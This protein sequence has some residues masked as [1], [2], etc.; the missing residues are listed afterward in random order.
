MAEWFDA[1]AQ[2]KRARTEMVLNEPYEL[3][4]E[5]RLIA[6]VPE[7]GSLGIHA[8]SDIEGEDLFVQFPLAE[9]DLAGAAEEVR[10]D[11]EQCRQ[12]RPP[13]PP[14]RTLV[15][16]IREGEEL[17][18]VKGDDRWVLMAPGSVVGTLR[19]PEPEQSSTHSTKLPGPVDWA[20]T[21]LYVPLYLLLVV[22]SVVPNILLKALRFSGIMG[23]SSQSF[24][25]GSGRAVAWT[26]ETA[27]DRWDFYIP[28]HPLLVTPWWNR[29]PPVIVKQAGSGREVARFEPSDSGF[30]T[31]GILGIAEGG[32]SFF[33][34]L[35]WW[36][37]ASYRTSL[38]HYKG[39]RNFEIE[40]ISVQI[41]PAATGMPELPLL[42][43]LGLFLEYWYLYEVAQRMPLENLWRRPA[44]RPRY[45]AAPYV[46]QQGGIQ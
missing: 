4:L 40:G 14:I 3:R 25:E 31:D 38:V 30:A 17:W 43:L 32:K 5:F 10:R 28:E 39:G 20:L 11:L 29:I 46:W 34:H 6:R 18:M 36:S 33:F 26:A 41:T 35:A 9:L 15:E 16:A 21:V 12:S 2:G 27:E 45:S 22:L 23:I 37:D 8:E 24:F 42:V 44:E 7:G 1:I 19:W 13:E